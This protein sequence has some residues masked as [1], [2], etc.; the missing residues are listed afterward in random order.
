[1]RHWMQLNNAAQLA[2][3]RRNLYARLWQLR[4]TKL[5]DRRYFIRGKMPICLK[6][7]PQRFR[8]SL[9]VLC[10]A[11]CTGSI[12]LQTLNYDTDQFEGMERR[13]SKE[14]RIVDSENDTP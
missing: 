13:S 3:L 5:S 6:A 2:H 4:I 14:D 1:M 10:Y 9:P 12:K 11:R 7:F 8:L